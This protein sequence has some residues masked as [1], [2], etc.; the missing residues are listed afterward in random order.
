MLPNPVNTFGSLIAQIATIK[1]ATKKKDKFNIFAGD[2]QTVTGIKTIS[3]DSVSAGK[4]YD[5]SGREVA[6]PSRGLYII[7]GKKVMI[8]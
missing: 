2:E 3:G 7:N 8:K 5:I 4:I 1:I 6:N